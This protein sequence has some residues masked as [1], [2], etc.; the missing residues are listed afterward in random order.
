MFT[1]SVLSFL[2]VLMHF[3]APDVSIFAWKI[4]IVGFSF[5]VITFASGTLIWFIGGIIGSSSAIYLS[6]ED[7]VISCAFGGVPCALICS[8]AIRRFLMT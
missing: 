7:W 1:L 5:P 4:L 3:L 2:M 6:H 8:L